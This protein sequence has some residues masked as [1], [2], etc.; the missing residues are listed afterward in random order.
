[1]NKALFLLSIFVIALWMSSCNEDKLNT[2]VNN[3]AKSNV[4]TNQ[5]MTNVP[6]NP[7]PT[8]QL[9]AA[10][11]PLISPK[12]MKNRYNSILDYTP[13]SLTPKELNAWLWPGESLKEKKNLFLPATVIPPKGDILFCFDLTGSM[14]GELNNVKINSQ[15]IMTAVRGVISDSKFGVISHMDYP[16]TYSNTCGYSG[17]YGSTGDYPYALNQALT[18]TTTDVSAA[19]S[20]LSLGYGN[21]EPEDYSRAFYESYSHA[22]IGFRTT[23]VKKI[24]VAFLDALP[25]D[26]D[27]YSILGLHTRTTGGD[28]GRD[29]TMGTSDDLAILDVL[30]GMKAAGISL[31]TVYSGYSGS[32]GALQYYDLWKKY[33]QRTGGDA[34]QIND[35]GTIPGGVD[36]AAYIADLIKGSIH[37]FDKLCLQVCDPAYASWLTP[38]CKEDVVLGT[39]QNLSFD[40]TFTVPVSTPPGDYCFDVCAIGDDLELAK[41]HVCITVPVSIDIK[42]GSCPNPI[43]YKDKG[44]LP[45]AILGNAYFDVNKI[46]VSSIRLIGVAPIRSSIE[47]TATP[48]NRKTDGCNDCTTKE[49]DAYTDL[50]LKFDVPD[51]VSAI[52]TAMNPND[53]DCVKL[54]LTA[55]LKPI[56]GSKLIQGSD[57]IRFQKNK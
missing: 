10:T 27:V 55:K 3:A 28:P 44:V 50:N 46:D 51:I 30:D 54:K 14:V 24:V 48:F 52:M 47:N 23:G 9:P 13:P 26:C 45:V 57:I 20:A 42:P 17:T 12:E 25:H 18:S 6:D 2:P 56:Y 31:I 21:D 43:E 40:L 33:S 35:D 16:A 41:Q 37:Q 38:V 5:Q 19:I 49:K 39:D 34:F 53:R 7:K 32:I 22:S 8:G 29:G 11:V 1:M 4:V 36:I 15:N